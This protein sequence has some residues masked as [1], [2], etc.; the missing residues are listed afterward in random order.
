MEFF[1]R[2]VKDAEQDH[3]RDCIVRDNKNEEKLLRIF[4]KNRSTVLE[5]PAFFQVRSVYMSLTTFIILTA[6]FLYRP[7]K[8][9][10]SGMSRSIISDKNTPSRCG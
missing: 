2:V 10:R 4:S 1:V 6:F 7:G 9:S 3:F 5:L 8:H